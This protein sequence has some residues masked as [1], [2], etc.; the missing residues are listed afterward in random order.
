MDR[1]QAKQVAQ[2]NR[3]ARPDILDQVKEEIGKLDNQNALLQ[4]K[5]HI[6]TE[7]SLFLLSFRTHLTGSA[8]YHV[9]TAKFNAV[10]G[11]MRQID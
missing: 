10:L 8:V 11:Q 1:M 5:L 6:D 3:K 7:F 9:L 2:E 4:V